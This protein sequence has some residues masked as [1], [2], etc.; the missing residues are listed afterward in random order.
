VKKTEDKQIEAR[1]AFDVTGP[2]VIT[3]SLRRS[4]AAVRRIINSNANSD[5]T[6]QAGWCI[7]KTDPNILFLAKN[8]RNFGT[9]KIRSR[10]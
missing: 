8:R 5:I 10:T 7:G 6:P 1:H 4:E 2:S 9:R 3:P